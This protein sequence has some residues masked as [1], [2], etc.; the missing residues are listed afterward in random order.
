MVSSARLTRLS[1][2]RAPHPPQVIL[3]AEE[4]QLDASDGCNGD[5]QAH[6]QAD[7]FPGLLRIT[8]HDI[9]A[10]H[11]QLL[12]PQVLVLRYE[13]RHQILF[14]KIECAR[15]AAHARSRS[16]RSLGWVRHVISRSIM[17]RR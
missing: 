5:C 1:A 14:Q 4:H 2:T 15:G 6:G 16:F 7:G 17:L 11:L 10:V 8:Y 9:D 13:L 12:A 3:D